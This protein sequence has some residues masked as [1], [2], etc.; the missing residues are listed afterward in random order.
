MRPLLLQLLPAVS[1]REVA[2]RRRCA[3]ITIAAGLF[4]FLYHIRGK[5]DVPEE[6]TDAICC[7]ASSNGQCWQIGTPNLL[8]Y[9]SKVHCKDGTVE[10]DWTVWVPSHLG[11]PKP[12]GSHQSQWQ[13]LA[14][15][16]SLVEVRQSNTSVQLYRVC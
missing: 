6:V 16:S 9:L 3:N 10:Q 5:D 11:F 4:D 14:F 2:V 1:E 7:M 12:F 8:Q 15:L 13:L